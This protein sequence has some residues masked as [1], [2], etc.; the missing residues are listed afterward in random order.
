MTRN[1]PAR[2]DATG[3]PTGAPRGHA[4]AWTRVVLVG[5]MGSGKTNVGRLLARRLGWRFVDLDEEVEAATGRT[6]EEIFR[7]RGEA[8]FREL[9]ATAGTAA[10][11]RDRTVLAP[12]GGW[13]LAPGRLE[14][15]PAGSLSVWL[16]VSAETAVRRATTLGRV[17][18]L[19]AGADPVDRA[20]A[21]IGER[22]PVYARAHLHLDTE[23]VTPAALVRAI[24]EHVEAKR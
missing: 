7:E 18:P 2:S 16:K 21:L 15:L 13:S 23:R 10:L 22:E 17:R 20:R 11:A 1:G 24:A 9:E 3:A 12:G 8:A 14:A 19:L 4:P 5:F 6:V